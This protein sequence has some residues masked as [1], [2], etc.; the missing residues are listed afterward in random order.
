MILADVV[1]FTD[2]INLG[3]IILF[4]TVVAAMYWAIRVNSARSWKDLAE[5]R[6]AIIDDMGDQLRI[7]NSRIDVLSGQ[8]DT[9]TKRP[10]TRDLVSALKDHEEQASRRHQSYTARSD[11]R[12]E[13][14]IQQLIKLVDRSV[15]A[16]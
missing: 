3:S 9:L 1:S 16:T 14:L 8:V 15:H 11:S 7:A 5:S 12:H 4:S 13:E 6:G 2:T 10:D